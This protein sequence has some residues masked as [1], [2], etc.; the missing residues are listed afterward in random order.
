[1]WADSVLKCAP[2]ILRAFSSIITDFADTKKFG[3]SYLVFE[4][5]Q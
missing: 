2:F 3:G 1:M 5:I 4:G